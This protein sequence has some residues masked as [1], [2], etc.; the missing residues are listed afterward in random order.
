MRAD[1][2]I[3]FLDT[4]KTTQVIVEQC[5]KCLLQMYSTICLVP[6]S[7]LPTSKHLVAYD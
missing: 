2:Y 1:E 7:E 6:E 4:T 3:C 5:L